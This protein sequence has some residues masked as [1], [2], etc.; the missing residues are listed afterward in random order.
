MTEWR[1]KFKSDLPPEHE[2]ETI[3]FKWR[4]Q[5]D[6][7]QSLLNGTHGASG[8]FLREYKARLVEIL[9]PQFPSLFDRPQEVNVGWAERSVGITN[10]EKLRKLAWLEMLRGKKIILIDMPDYSKTDK[11]MMAK[12]LDEIYWLWSALTL[13]RDLD[14]KKPNVVIAIQKE[15]FGSHFFFDK[16]QK[17][18]LEPLQPGQMIQ[19]YRRRFNGS[20]PFTEDALLSLASLSR[21]ICRRFLRYISL[22]LDLWEAEGRKTELVD[23]STVKGAVTTE[24]LGEDMELE[25]S[26]LFPKHSELRS[27]ALRV[28]LGLQEFGPTKQSQ[29]AE[30]LDIE[31]YALSRL[32]TKLELRHYIKRLREGNDKIVSLP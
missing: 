14:P 32:L 4:R 17:I 30:K 15:M 10:A 16:M 24:R 12:D 25:L 7:F 9:L 18:E 31:E 19:A 2:Y 21:G 20:E 11:R 1:A 28:L 8:S 3:L 22:T 23:V 13:P 6:L 27:Q 29:L 5:A 26:E